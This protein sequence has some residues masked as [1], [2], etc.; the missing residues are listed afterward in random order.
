MKKPLVRLI[1]EEHCV[2]VYLDKKTPP[3][4]AIPKEKIRT[5]VVKNPC[6][7][8]HEEV[9]RRAKE[10]STFIPS[11]ANC[12]V[13]SEFNPDTQHQKEGKMYSVYAIQFYNALE[14]ELRK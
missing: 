11:N 7:D 14:S 2:G 12:Y 1:Q 4:R 13:I 8:L 9:Q 6:L 10:N 3:V 5:L